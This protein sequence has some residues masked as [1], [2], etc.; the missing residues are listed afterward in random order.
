MIGDLDVFKFESSLVAHPC[1]CRVI[2]SRMVPTLGCFALA[3]LLKDEF[4]G[5]PI[6]A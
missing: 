5:F 3:S 1:Q 6:E 4:E 2:R